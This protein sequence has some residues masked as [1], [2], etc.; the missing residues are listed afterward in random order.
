MVVAV[1]VAVVASSVRVGG[2]ERGVSVRT[3]EEGE[4]A[5]LGAVG[6]CRVER[7]WRVVVGVLWSAFACSVFVQVD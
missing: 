7:R 1:V 2:R 4:R 3:S 6:G 5:G